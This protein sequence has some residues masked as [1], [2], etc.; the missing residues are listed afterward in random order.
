MITKSEKSLVI[1]DEFSNENFGW[2]CDVDGIDVVI[3]KKEESGVGGRE[4]WRKE[5]IVVT[6]ESKQ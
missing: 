1:K 4:D 2:E 3:E 5:L 6:C